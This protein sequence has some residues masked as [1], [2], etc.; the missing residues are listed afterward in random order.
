MGTAAPGTKSVF[1][2]SRQGTRQQVTV[3]ILLTANS[4]SLIVQIVVAVFQ[5]DFRR[6]FGVGGEGTEQCKILN[7]L[8]A[9]LY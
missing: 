9:I 7:I 6:L 3:D 2:Q 8:S 5:I 1:R 4:F